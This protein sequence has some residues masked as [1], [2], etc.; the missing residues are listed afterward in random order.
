MT[1]RAYGS[2]LTTPYRPS[3]VRAPPLDRSFGA[4]ER[5]PAKGMAGIGK[6][7]RDDRS[8]RP[9]GFAEPIPVGSDLRPDTSVTILIGGVP[10]SGKSSLAAA[11]G[12]KLRW[13]LVHSDQI[14]GAFRVPHAGNVT[15]PKQL[16]RLTQ[17]A[18][19]GYGA[20]QLK[21]FESSRIIEGTHFDPAAVA[22]H[23]TADPDRWCVAFLGYANIDVDE[24]IEMIRAT[25]GD[26]H[27]WTVHRS[28]EE[29]RENIELLVRQSAVRRTQCEEHGFAYFE[30]GRDHAEDLTRAANAILEMI[31]DEA[32]RQ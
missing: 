18:M 9:E 26:R 2:R 25:E 24:K 21:D 7:S 27:A 14:A 3:P 22:R 28:D 5:R 12:R 17:T 4:R 20:K 19:L 31:P 6:T 15:D 30:I 8:G 13:P 23:V 32:F 16:F 1:R 29:L 10:R 11:L